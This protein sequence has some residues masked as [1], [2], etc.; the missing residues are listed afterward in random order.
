MMELQKRYKNLMVEYLRSCGLSTR[1]SMKGGQFTGNELKDLTKP[2]NLATLERML[3]PV[4][5]MVGDLT[6]Y[7]QSLRD[8]HRLCVS[9]KLAGNYKE[10]NLLS[11]PNSVYISQDIL[12]SKI[13][14]KYYDIMIKLIINV[15]KY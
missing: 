1:R 5:P 2:S 15:I 8:L 4:C 11:L 6:A 3:L 13:I 7:I 9:K 14:L 12:V 10:V